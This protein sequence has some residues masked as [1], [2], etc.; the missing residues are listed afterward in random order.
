M[1]SWM[2]RN[3]FSQTFHSPGPPSPPL[4]LVKPIFKGSSKFVTPDSSHHNSEFQSSHRILIDKLGTSDLADQP[5]AFKFSASQQRKRR[6]KLCYHITPSAGDNLHNS[7]LDPSRIRDARF[8]NPQCRQIIDSLKWGKLQKSKAGAG[9]VI[10]WEE[11]YTII[12]GFLYH[13]FT[14]HGSQPHKASA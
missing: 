5:Q 14:S 11:D 13:V 7:G 3:V 1:T 8:R 4:L 6:D 2:Q 9:A 12:N 10:L